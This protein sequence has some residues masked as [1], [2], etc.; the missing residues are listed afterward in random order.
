ML[1]R[2]IEFIKKHKNDYKGELFDFNDFVL[3]MICDIMKMAAQIMVIF[4]K[5]YKSHKKGES[6]KIR[7]FTLVIIF[8]IFPQK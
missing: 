6:M 4:V 8:V 3:Y 2:E 5:N 7:K 1:E